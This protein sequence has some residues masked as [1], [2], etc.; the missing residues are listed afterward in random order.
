MTLVLDGDAEIAGA[1]EITSPLEGSEHPESPYG[2]GPAGRPGPEGRPGQVTDLH[3]DS[4]LSGGTR[5]DCANIL[6]Q[7]PNNKIDSAT[8]LSAIGKTFG[9]M[10]SSETQ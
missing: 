1:P 4:F 7:F 5:R 6:H 3:V 2:T 9:V 10:G 8:M